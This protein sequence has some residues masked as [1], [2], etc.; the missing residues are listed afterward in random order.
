MEKQEEWLKYI[1]STKYEGLIFVDRDGIIR[2]VN[3]AFTT[4]LGLTESD[5]LGTHISS[6]Q[7]DPGL[8]EVIKT[9]KP[10]IL[11]YY[12]EAKLIASRQPVFDNGELIGV[13]G[14]YVALDTYAVRKNI[15]EKEEFI[16]IVSKIK[17]KDIMVQTGYL[18]AELNSYRDEFARLHSTSVGIHNIV[19]ESSRELKELVLKI[20][21]SPSTVLITGESGTGK[22]LY[23]QAIHYHSDRAGGPFIKVNC[24]AIPESLLE[25]ELFGYVEGAFTG[26][27]KGGKLG[28]FHLASGGTIFLDEIAEMPWSMQAK[29]LR[30]LQ[31]KEVEPIGAEKPVKVDVRVISATNADLVKLVDSGRFRHDLFYRLNVVHLHIPPLRERP[32]DI[33]TIANHVIRQLNIKLE[34]K[35]EGISS[36]AMQL[37]LAHDWPGNVRE[38]INVLERAMNFC[39]SNTIEPEDLPPYIRQ[40]GK[41]YQP[42]GFDL[43]ER[44]E[45]A[46]KEAVMKALKAAGGKRKE[47]ASMLGISRTTLF[48]LMKRYGL[49]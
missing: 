11:S 5:L 26:A 25:S 12:P 36:E 24:A 10:D 8:L 31:E 37:L 28:K 35:V 1:A 4:Y 21:A 29:L 42:K 33:V 45:E 22:E 38:L 2:Y 43:N 9:G 47:A 7:I 49:R 40:K 16:D 44:L 23:A 13:C 3:Q 27:K 46:Q 41:H 17:T 30:V 48:R 6:L 18:L 34:Q 14:R 32:Q 39:H 19:G 15:L 20:A